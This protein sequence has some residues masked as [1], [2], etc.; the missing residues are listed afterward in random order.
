MY[1]ECLSPESLGPIAA[2]APLLQQLEQLLRN[3]APL[4]PLLDDTA[5]LLRCMTAALKLPGAAQMKVI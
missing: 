3:V 4:L 5:P 2:C 1:I